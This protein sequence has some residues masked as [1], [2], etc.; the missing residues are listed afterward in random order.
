M[1]TS[2]ASPENIMYEIIKRSS[3]LRN[4]RAWYMKVSFLQNSVQE[5]MMPHLPYADPDAWR[6]I[7][8]YMGMEVMHIEE[9]SK[10]DVFLA[11]IGEDGCYCVFFSRGQFGKCRTSKLQHD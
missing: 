7:S 10:I 4:P 2:L 11:E 6:Y 8:S 3:T 1:I 5:I 9:D